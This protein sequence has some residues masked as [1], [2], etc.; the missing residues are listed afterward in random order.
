MIAFYIISFC[1]IAYN[2][3]TVIWNLFYAFSYIQLLTCS[4]AIENTGS[5]KYVAIDKK[6]K[7]V[8]Y[9][10]NNSDDYLFYYCYNYNYSD[11]IT[12][13]KFINVDL[14]INGKS[15]NLDL[16]T[17]DKTYY[18]INNKILG[19]KFIKWYMN[20]YFKNNICDCDYEISII[21]NCANIITLLPSQ[22]IVLEKENYVIKNI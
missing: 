8:D 7:T 16:Q 21:D 9:C 17:K 18:L 5:I 12:K 20:H 11:K 3:K 6:F 19:K 15:I 14:R 4:K 13:W 1:I 22:Y 10:E 2:W